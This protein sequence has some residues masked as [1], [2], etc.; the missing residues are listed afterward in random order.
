MLS[1][2][3]NTRSST[4]DEFDREALTATLARRLVPVD[5]TISATGDDDGSDVTYGATS[6]RGPLPFSTPPGSSSTALATSRR[7]S[8]PG[9]R[10]SRSRM[11]AKLLDRVLRRRSFRVSPASAVVVPAPSTGQPRRLRLSGRTIL[12]TGA[13]SASALPRPIASPGWRHPARRRPQS[14]RPTPPAQPSS[15]PERP[16]PPV[17]RPRRPRR[18]GT[19]RHGDRL[20]RR[21]HLIHNA[22]APGRTSRTPTASSTVASQVLAVPAHRR[23]LPT[24][25]SNGPARPDHVV[26]RHVQRPH[27]TA[28]K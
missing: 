21:P 15:R 20:A 9:P 19:R 10:R 22:G 1:S 24:L 14:G 2:A 28:S 3:G 13:T 17:R 11:S 12:L 18:V 7:W 25:R 27:A 8:H 26:G 23:L 4:S 5:D 16:T 6:N